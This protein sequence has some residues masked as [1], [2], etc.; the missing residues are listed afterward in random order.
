MNVLLLVSTVLLASNDIVGSVHRDT[1]FIYLD[2]SA[3]SF[4]IT[5]LAENPCP[6]TAIKEPNPTA[7]KEPSSDDNN[8]ETDKRCYLISLQFIN[9]TT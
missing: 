3:S 8:I 4:R 7:I 1:A 9:I 2:Y 5:L 6:P